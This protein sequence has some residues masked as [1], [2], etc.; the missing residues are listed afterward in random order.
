MESLSS[1]EIVELILM[2][3][4]SLDLQLQFWLTATFAVVAASFLA[5]TRLGQFYRILVAI[6]YVIFTAMIMTR[7]AREGLEM[8]AMMD[9]IQSRGL[10]FDLPV[11]SGALRFTLMVVGSGAALF[12][13]YKD[14]KGDGRDA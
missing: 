11:V 6:L 7:W 3:R 14:R 12:F 9:E 8:V 5:G 10:P 4:S 2:Q 13:L 1:A